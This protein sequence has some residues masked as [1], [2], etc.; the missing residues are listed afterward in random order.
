MMAKGSKALEDTEFSESD[1]SSNSSKERPMGEMKEGK[2]LPY[3]FE[4]SPQKCPKKRK[5][6]SFESLASSK[7]WKN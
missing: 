2:I 7:E 3:G 4:M 6:F 1:G 5:A